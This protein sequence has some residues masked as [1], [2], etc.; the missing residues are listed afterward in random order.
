MALS[1]RNWNNIIIFCSV[2]MVATLSFLYE[3]TDH[4][5]DNS[6]V[7]FD[8][9]APL[10]QLEQN[11]WWM[12]HRDNNW[13]CSSDIKNCPIWVEAWRN[14][15]VSIVEHPTLPTEPPQHLTIT[16]KDIPHSQ[17]W[18]YYPDAGLLQSA[19]G[20]W[21]LV[22]PSLRAGLIPETAANVQG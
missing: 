6:Q 18:Q 10:A 19:N 12:A 1:R 2:A 20:A 15:H 16:I 4:L 13:L 9:Q 21:Y 8:A 22:P 5:P 17:H 11:D 7:L 3:K 14:V